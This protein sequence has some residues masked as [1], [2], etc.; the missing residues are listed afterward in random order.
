M[1]FKVL[2]LRGTAAQNATYTG[3]DGEMTVD[4]TNRALRI[5]D[6]VTAGGHEILGAGQVNTLISQLADRI[7]NGD[8]GIDDINTVIEAIQTELAGKILATEKG[9]A[10]GVATLDANGKVPLAQI[11]DSVLGQVEYM[12]TWDAESNV[13]ELPATPLNK[14]EYYV[15]AVSGDFEGVEYTV[16]D[17]IISNGSIWE[18]VDN[19]DAV[20]SI[21]GK[22][23]VVVLTKADVGL[24]QVDNTSDLDKPVSTAQQAALDLKA[25]LSYVDAE[26]GK[27]DTGVSSVSGTGA[28]TVDTS[29][30]ANPVVSITAATA[31]A[32]GS[33]SAAHFSKLEGVEAGAQVNTV[34][35]VAGKVGDVE[36][37]KA[38]VGL[39][40]VE[41]FGVATEAQAQEA[42]AND[43][44]MTPQRTR[45]FVE[46]V[47]FSQDSET[48]HWMLDQ[49]SMV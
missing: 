17:W 24:D 49:G 38:D 33:M 18:K 48:G 31:E 8:A 9:A 13:P 20:S 22:T 10:N 7:D 2:F 3:A 34:T 41:N 40:S 29:D 15:V 27:L 43:A 11:S 37:E 45:D 35:S 32:A 26:L 19:T 12:G 5:H 4:V 42:L 28:I 21:N 1:S 36:L 46:H 16:G 47:G 25:D 39:G 14:G 30:S 44:Y 6:G 23:G